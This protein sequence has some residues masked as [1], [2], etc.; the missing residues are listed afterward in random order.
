MYSCLKPTLGFFVPDSPTPITVSTKHSLFTA[1][2]LKSESFMPFSFSFRATTLSKVVWHSTGFPTIHWAFNW[3]DESSL[4]LIIT[5]APRL[6]PS[7]LQFPGQ[8]LQPCLNGTDSTSNAV[9]LL[10]SCKLPF[11]SNHLRVH[12]FVSGTP[13]HFLFR[14]RRLMRGSGDVGVGS[15]N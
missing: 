13:R 3:S 15:G 2:G 6:H 1:L 14:C 12:R 8:P 9:A 7:N 4:T 10:C 11:G 5:K